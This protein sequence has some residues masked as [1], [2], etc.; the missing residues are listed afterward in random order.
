M[1]SKLLLCALAVL[2]LGL[3]LGALA[4]EVDCDATYCFS[5]EDFATAQEALEGICITGL[6]DP[7]TGTVMLGT[8]VLRKGDILS[9]GQ[10][11]DMTF[12]PLQT[13]TDAT[14]TVQYLPIYQNRVDTVSTMTISIRGKENQ[15]S[16][17]HEL[18]VFRTL[19]KACNA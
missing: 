14:A 1:F 5:Q 19:M 11:A 15:W 10:L 2:M 12:H 8:R 7:D 4:A 9:A 3:P 16:L 18:A 6:P 13:G 17:D